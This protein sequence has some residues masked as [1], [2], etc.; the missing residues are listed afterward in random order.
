MAFPETKWT[1]LAQATLNGD[2]A[3]RAA[4]EELCRRYW[5]A[6]RD[7]LV[8]RGYAPEEAE[9][10]AQDFFSSLMQSGGWHHADR[11][12]GRFRNFLLGA[13]ER[14]LVQRR[15]RATAQKRGGGAAAVSLE[16]IAEVAAEGDERQFDTAWAERV[17]EVAMDA[18]E[19]ECAEEGRGGEFG[20]LVPFLGTSADA[21]SGGAAS[22]ALGVSEAAVKSKVFR[23]RQRFRD[24]ILAEISRTVE[25][26]H[27]AEE[28]MAWLFAVL[29]QPGV[30]LR[31]ETGAEI[32]PEKEQ[33]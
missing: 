19:R 24:A 4:L 30:A 15:R 3:G 25:T 26:P 29:S 10:A 18:L 33:P 22:A 11:A 23:L 31:R 32:L 20:M 8:L 17:L 28:E 16:E 1:M 12:R 21:K 14:T 7:F 9:D 5:P 2:A 6:V 13:L 27:E